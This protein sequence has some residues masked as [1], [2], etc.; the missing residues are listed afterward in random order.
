MSITAALI[1]SSSVLFATTET[2][3]AKGEKPKYTREQIVAMHAA[4]LAADGGLVE[5]PVKGKVVRIKVETSRITPAE[6][7]QEAVT[8][9]RRL[10][11]SVEVGAKGTE[12]KHEVGAYVVLADQGEK[13]PTLLC[14][15]EEN[16]ATVNVT[17]LLAG[18]P[19]AATLKS[20]IIK[21]LWRAL[22]YALG[23]ANSQQQPC[24]MR[25]IRKA[26]DLDT[27]PVAMVTPMPLMAMRNTMASIG[28]AA[29]GMTSYRKA[30]EEG[31]AP[32]PTNDVQKAV[33]DKV[34]EVPK[35]PIKIE[36]DPKKGE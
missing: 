4:R 31:W 8:I 32:A 15:P 11:A 36:F 29:G 25:P 3:K 2:T 1:L 18:D 20:R 35:K 13:V 22:G 9:R 30:C 33:W 26:S 34:H 16:W 10:S 17:R 21:E 14:A 27:Y 19:D 5:R 28:F 23:A 6:I 7:E 24:V 12:S